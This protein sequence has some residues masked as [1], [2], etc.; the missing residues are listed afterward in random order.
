[1]WRGGS[2]PFSSILDS[3][4]ISVIVTFDLLS[5]ITERLFRAYPVVSS[6]VFEMVEAPPVEKV[7]TYS[8]V[9]TL[10]SHTDDS[11]ASISSTSL[12]FLDQPV[13]DNLAC[14]GITQF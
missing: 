2:N 1:M 5:P 12:P 14:S 9:G 11:R 6:E 7:V 4:E 10:F 8:T 13:R 3:T